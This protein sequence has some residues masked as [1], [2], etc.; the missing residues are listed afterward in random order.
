MILSYII[1]VS[2]KSRVNL[3]SMVHLL[4]CQD[5]AVCLLS[6]KIIKISYMPFRSFWIQEATYFSFQRFLYAATYKSAHL[7]GTP[8]TKRFSKSVQ[9]EMQQC[10]LV[11]PA[12]IPLRGWITSGGHELPK[13]LWCRKTTLLCSLLFSTREA[14]SGFLLGSAPKLQPIKALNL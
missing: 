3:S 13:D 6:N 5:V 12:E 1:K 2:R 11:L 14:I 7:N 8:P 4:H 10:L 9:T